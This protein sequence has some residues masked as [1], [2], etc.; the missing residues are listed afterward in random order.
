MRTDERVARLHHPVVWLI[1]T[2]SI[3]MGPAMLDVLHPGG[4]G[5]PAVAKPAG[6]P[7]SPVMSRTPS[8]V[9]NMPQVECSIVADLRREGCQACTWIAAGRRLAI[10]PRLRGALHRS[11][12]RA[13]P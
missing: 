4:D 5:R 11:A 3:L 9:K 12:L 6:Q 8:G 7:M 10:S 2:T 1:Q 13:S